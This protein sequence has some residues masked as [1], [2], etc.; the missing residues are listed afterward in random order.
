MPEWL[1]KIS[2]AEIVAV[3]GVLGSLVAWVVALRDKASARIITELRTILEGQ[4][5][6]NGR[7]RDAQADYRAKAEA[8]EERER[9]AND[10]ADA[11]EKALADRL[12]L[13]TVHGV[14]FFERD[15][16]AGP[17][18]PKCMLPMS[19]TEQ[20]FVCTCG[21]EVSNFEVKKRMQSL[22]IL[23][24]YEDI[25]ERM[26]PITQSIWSAYLK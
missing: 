1:S 3:L 10:R 12:K 4:R 18:C 9:I 25:V 5:I 23:P 6:E 14:S 20:A 24:G 21:R 13:I 7:L 22:S 2:F 15:L 26:D 17:V 16:L 11:A 8:H 19:P